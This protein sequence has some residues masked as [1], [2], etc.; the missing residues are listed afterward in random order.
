FSFSVL[1]VVL[2]GRSPHLN[3]L[4]LESRKDLEIAKNCLSLTDSLDLAERD[5]NELSGGE[6]QRVIIAKALA[7]QPHILILDEPTV[8]FP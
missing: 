4:Q 5:I 3:R 7:Q 6:R 2:M 1:E 8:I